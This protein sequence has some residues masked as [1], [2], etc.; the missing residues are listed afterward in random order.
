MRLARQL[1]FIPAAFLLALASVSSHA[2]GFEGTGF[3]DKVE[4]GKNLVTVGE[5]TFYL[6]NSTLLDGGPAIF[7]L[8]P[9]YQV[10]F[11][12]NVDNRHPTITSIYLYPE[13]VVLAE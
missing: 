6:P 3:I 1:I 7:Q 12:G 5:E 13:S 4:L 10:N 9:G 8:K 2:Q 11:S